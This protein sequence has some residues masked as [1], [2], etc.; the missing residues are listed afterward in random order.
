MQLIFVLLF[1]FLGI[2]L[3]AHQYNI[4]TRLLI[5]AVIAGVLLLLYFTSAE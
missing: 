2:G 4:R 1:L 5:A 3:F